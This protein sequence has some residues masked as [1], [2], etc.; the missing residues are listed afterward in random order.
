VA[1]SVGFVPTA[2]VFWFVHSSLPGASE[3]GEPH[4]SRW[5]SY[6]LFLFGI[7]FTFWSFIC[8][9]SE[10]S[11]FSSAF[12]SLQSFRVGFAHSHILWGRLSLAITRHYFLLCWQLRFPYFVLSRVLHARA[13][14]VRRFSEEPS[15]LALPHRQPLCYSH[16]FFESVER[17][18]YS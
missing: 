17:M 6:M 7:L 3:V 8:I 14:D 18:F 4:S 10:T 13:A 1:F 15:A 9:N 11:S 5:I 12:S 2:R 16:L